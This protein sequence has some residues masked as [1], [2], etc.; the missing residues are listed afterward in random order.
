M[1]FERA[2][3]KCGRRYKN[4]LEEKIIGKGS[5]NRE[6]VRAK[7]NPGASPKLFG[8]REKNGSRFGEASQGCGT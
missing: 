2:R 4:V 1:D 7:R 8:S 5:N 3:K 6:T